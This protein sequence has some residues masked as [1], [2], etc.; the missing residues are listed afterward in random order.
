MRPS[1]IGLLLLF[2]LPVELVDVFAD[3]DRQEPVRLWPDNLFGVDF[4]DRSF[5]VISGYAG[6]VLRT[7]DGGRSW[8]WIY[9][10]VDEL[11][12]RV[13]FVDTEQGWAVGHR[14]SILHTADGGLTWSVQHTE[15]NTYLRDVYFVDRDSGWAVG[16]DAVILHTENGGVSWEKQALTGFKGR[17]LPR[18]HGVFADNPRV[19]VLVGEF[20][21]VAQTD[22]RGATWSVQKSS[23]NKTLLDVAGTGNRYV[24]VGLDGTVVA[25]SRR[26]GMLD[27]DGSGPV[28]ESLDNSSAEHFFA[29]APVGDG[30]VLAVGRSVA[31][32]INDGTVSH[33]T[34]DASIQLPFTWFGGVDVLDDGTFWLAGIRG[35][36]ARGD[37]AARSFRAA[38]TLGRS[39][40]ITIVS[41]R[42]AAAK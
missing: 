6:T 12:R 9:I 42:W 32:L 28:V 29:V 17:D 14:G 15:P 27:E 16:H 36:V 21:V 4:V 34:P 22:D 26:A 11:I 40:A 37:V 8:E 35:T 38:L 33:M 25:I 24:A 1:L 10:G 3:S 41:N 23:T 31:A 20:G 13:S 7:Q 18:L 5:G 30:G 19:A 2:A 39:D